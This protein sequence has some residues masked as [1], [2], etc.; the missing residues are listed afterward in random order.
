MGSE[1]SPR[2]PN[3]GGLPPITINGLTHIGVGNFTPTL[4]Y[5]WSVEGSDG[6]TRVFRNH[7]FKTGVQVDDL[8]GDIS[9]PPQGR[10]DLNF[11]GQ[12]TDIPNV[13]NNLNGIADLLLVPIHLFSWRH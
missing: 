7:T 8:E 4:Q 12:Y 9:Q 6:I 13:N 1:E 5:V 2:L 11:N 3:N 10:G